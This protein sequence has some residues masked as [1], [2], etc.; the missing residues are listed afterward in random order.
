MAK[1]VCKKASELEMEQ[2]EG[3]KKDVRDK[4]LDLLRESDSWL[5]PD[6]FGP[7]EDII[8]YRQALRDVTE[9]NGFPFNI[10]WPEKPVLD[11]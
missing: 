2:L 10:I 5:L 7:R 9:Q 8:E 11:K 4:R 6:R 1:L 3:I